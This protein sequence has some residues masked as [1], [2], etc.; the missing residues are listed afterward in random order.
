MQ[1]HQALFQ[2]GHRELVIV[3][4]DPLHDGLVQEDVL[5]L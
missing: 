1:L 5:V 3:M 4:S 2:A